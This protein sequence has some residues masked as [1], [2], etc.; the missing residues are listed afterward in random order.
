MKRIWEFIGDRAYIFMLVGMIIGV[1]GLL[2]LMKF[3]KTEGPKSYALVLGIFG[4]T[5]YL[6][7]RISLFFKNKRTKNNREK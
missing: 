6:L 5:I 1:T 7:G 2:F 4:I 3:N